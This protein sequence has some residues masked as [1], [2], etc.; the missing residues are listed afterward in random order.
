MHGYVHARRMLSTWHE[1]RELNARQQGGG[2]AMR[3]GGPWSPATYDPWRLGHNAVQSYNMALV[4]AAAAGAGSHQHP[5]HQ[6]PQRADAT[7]AA[8]T[9]SGSIS[10]AIPFSNGFSA[11]VEAVGPEAFDIT[12]DLGSLSGGGS[13]GHDEKA[14]SS[15]AAAASAAADD[16]IK[17][18][19]ARL[20]TP[21]ADK[22]EAEVD[23]RWLVADVL[24]RRTAGPAGVSGGGAGGSAES[25]GS[26]S[27]RV[28]MDF[29]A[30]GQHWQM[31][32]TTPEGASRR[33]RTAVDG[34]SAAESGVS[35]AASA[36]GAVVAPMPGRVTRVLVRH[37]DAVAAGAV[38]VVLEAMKME[39][40]VRAATAGRVSMVGVG[41]SPGAHVSDGQVLLT[42]VQD[43][44]TRS[45][46]PQEGDG[47]K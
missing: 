31:Q 15:T 5:H 2:S 23:G 45:A 28:L 37:G 6:A 22:I 7:T 11:R 34:K 13:T 36:A 38:V 20:V 9:S 47:K 3:V 8:S 24:V 10:G 27:R 32:W 29:W 14:D 25:S 40:S 18:R 35:A 44:A 39:H 12:V 46:V 42:V 30:A 19:N 1:Q 21:S 43:D 26:S 16:I 33:R 17:V 41:L 4:T